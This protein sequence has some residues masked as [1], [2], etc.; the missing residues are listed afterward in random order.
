MPDA[1]RYSV[2]IFG[3]RLDPHVE[4]VSAHLLAAGAEVEIFDQWSDETAIDIDAARGLRWPVLERLGAADG[5]AIWNR[6][7]PLMSEANGHLL[8]RVEPATTSDEA[9]MQAFW[10]A[11]WTHFSHGLIHLAQ[12]SL[13]RVRVLNGVTAERT[14]NLKPLQLVAARAAGFSIPD[15]TIGNSTEAI[16]ARGEPMLLIKSLS[17]EVFNSRGPAPVAELSV[18]AMVASGSVPLCPVI[19]Q[20]RVEKAFELRVNVAGEAVRATLIRSQEHNV[21]ALDWRVGSTLPG[22]YEVFEL[23][24]S[25]VARI[26]VFMNLM[27][28]DAGALDFAV[29]PQGEYVFFECNPAGQWLWIEEC[30]GTPI[31]HDIALLLLKLAGE[32]AST[33]HHSHLSADDAVAV[34]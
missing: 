9:K 27:Q 22:L 19:Y 18:E 2:L 30:L 13:S 23:P 5:V 1:K 34:G 26:R 31:S 17:N 32:A 8:R 24:A 33:R 7:K 11:Q 20:N 25:V 12:R 14:A 15:T 28:L 4:E 16:L 21:T 3:Q 6:S 29:T 10:K